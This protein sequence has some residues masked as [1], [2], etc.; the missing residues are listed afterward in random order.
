MTL[1]SKFYD[2]FRAKTYDAELEDITAE[3][4][5]MAVAALNLQP[6][7]TVIDL[8]CGTGLN[9]PYL[10]KALGGEGRIIGLDASSGM[11]AEAQK[12]ADRDGY[13][14][15]LTL[16]EGDARKLTQ[17]LAPTLLGAP[18]DALLTTLFM[19]VAPNW[20]QVFADAFDLVR[21]GGRAAVMDTYWPKQS[22]REFLISSRYAASAY[23]P[24]H[25]PLKERAVDFQMVTHPPDV[26]GFF[27]ASGSK[28]AWSP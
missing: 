16:I 2:L 3:A 6:G 10:A 9:H 28:S 22:L 14:E 11:L 5:S 8:G 18:V 7:M 19:S 1:K 26:N 20:R 12:R 13:R 17:L 27:I 15:I 24:G 4:R 21:P 25:E 23:R